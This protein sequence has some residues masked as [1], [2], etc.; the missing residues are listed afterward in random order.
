MAGSGRLTTHVL[1]TMHGKPARGMRFDLADGARRPQPSHPRPRDTNADGRVDQPLLEGDR[2]HH[3]R[4]RADLP[5]RASISSGWASMLETPVPRHGAGPLHDHRGGAL[6]RAAAGLALRLLDLSGQLMTAGARSA[7]SSTTRTSR[8]TELAPTATLLDFLRLDKRLRGSKEGCAEGDCGACTVLVGRLSGDE[9]VYET[10]NACISLRRHAARHACG[11]R[12]APRAATA[13]LHPVQQAMVDYHGS[14]CGFC[15]PGFVMSL[16]GLWMQEPQPSVPQIETR[17]A[18]QPLPLHRL[19]AD[20]QGRARRCTSTADPEKRS[21]G[22]RTRR[23]EGAG[24]GDQRRRD[25][26]RSARA[27]HRLIVPARSTI[28][29]RSMPPTRTRRSSPARPMS[30]SGSRSSCATSGR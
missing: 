12:R 30:A 2:F 6:P 14:Q 25:A 27:R 26:S 28:S 29:P 20:R 11:H 18:G 10:V 5:R 7:S 13:P 22:R 23:D 8:S 21:A 24:Q 1:D 3:G 16:Y 15:T 9:L 19:C 17:A 4:V